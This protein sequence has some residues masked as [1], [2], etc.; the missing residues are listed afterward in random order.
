MFSD[1]GACILIGWEC[2]ALHATIGPLRRLLSI[3][4]APRRAVAWGTPFVRLITGTRFWGCV[5]AVSLDLFMF[6][7]FFG[8]GS[9]GFDPKVSVWCTRFYCVSASKQLSA[10]CFLDTG[11]ADFCFITFIMVVS[12]SMALSMLA[13]CFAP[14]GGVWTCARAEEDLCLTRGD[15]I[16]MRKLCC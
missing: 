5:T 15:L 16:P 12:I 10:I 13:V 4:A 1:F 11:F 2:I 7:W 14:L 8:V 6:V 3:R 9:C